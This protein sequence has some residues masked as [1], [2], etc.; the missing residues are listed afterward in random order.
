MRRRHHSDRVLGMQLFDDSFPHRDVI[1]GA[2]EAHVVHVTDQ[3]QP[4]RYADARC[5]CQQPPSQLR[6]HL[7]TTVSTSIEQCNDRYTGHLTCGQ[8]YIWYSGEDLDALAP[9]YQT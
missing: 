7:T 5:T 1:V 4:L 9:L 6:K 2:V 3:P 8:F